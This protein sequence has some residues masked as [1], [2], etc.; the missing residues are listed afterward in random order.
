MFLISRP[1][2][3]HPQLRRP[4]RHCM[5][6]RD[7]V[8]PP[9]AG[10]AHDLCMRDSPPNNQ[11]KPIMLPNVVG[12]PSRSLITSHYPNMSFSSALSR[13]IPLCFPQDGRR[14]AGSAL[15]EL[16]VVRRSSCASAP[17]TPA[18]PHHLQIVPSNRTAVLHK[19]NHKS[20]PSPSGP[21]YLDSLELGFHSSFHVAQMASQDHEHPAC[22]PQR[23][24]ERKDVVDVP[25]H[26]EAPAGCTAVD[27]QAM[28]S[29]L[30]LQGGDRAPTFRLRL[31]F[32]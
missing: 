9:E 18:C 15:Q 10:G 25:R 26:C 29:Q 5:Q 12:A 3:V 6:N 19:A 27:G 20:S 1:P 30:C 13:H 32:V 31:P 16:Q 14:L 22:A 11:H 2:S 7:P 4:S 24:S 8:H 28:G 21:G 23:A 17:A